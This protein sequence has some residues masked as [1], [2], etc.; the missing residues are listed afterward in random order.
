MSNALPPIALVHGWGGSYE[1]TYGA[2]GWGAALAAAGRQVIEIDL[3]GHG[4]KTQWSHNPAAY[5][6]MAG[7]LD[8]M[9]PAGVLDAVGFSLGAKVVLELACRAP[10]RFRRIVVGGLGNNAFDKELGGVVAAA[11]DQGL[12]AE[13]RARM[14]L[15]ANYIDE[16]PSDYRAI[17]AVNRRPHN[18]IADAARL[19]TITS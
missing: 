10:T 12:P 5:A 6:D 19:A 4:R 17:A 3:P 14:P 13:F 11:L 8:E 18:P 9:L 2:T 1:G 15:V 16:S 7:G